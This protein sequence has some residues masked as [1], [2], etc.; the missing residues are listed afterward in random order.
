MR[1][2]WVYAREKIVL[3]ATGFE[4][5]ARQ[6]ERRVGRRR[7]RGGGPEVLV[8]GVVWAH[9]LLCPVLSLHVRSRVCWGLRA[10]SSICVCDS[11]CV[12][13]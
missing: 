12:C 5:E 4:E 3:S 1:L 7:R 13:V 6:T 9:V 10:C 11:V 8:G 2:D